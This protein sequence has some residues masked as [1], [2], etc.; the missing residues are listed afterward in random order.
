MNDYHTGY[1][2]IIGRPNVGKSTLLNFLLEQ[3]LSIVSRK[4]Q[5]TRYNLLGIKTTSN[6]QIIY[7]DTPGLQKK[8][9]LALNRYMN[10]EVINAL[11]HVDIIL[12]VVE[13][14][15]WNELDDNVVSVLGNIK[16]KILVL[17]NKTDK[18]INKKELLPFIEKINSKLDVLDIIPISAKKGEGVGKL[19]EFI[20][21]NLPKGPAIFSESS[22]TDR[23]ERFFAAEFLREK[24]M[25]R[26]GEEI[27]YR[28]TIT[29]DSFQDIDNIY[30]IHASIWV[31]KP[32]QK[33]IVIGK[34]GRILKAAGQEARLDLEKL[35][36]KK[37]NLKTWVK[38]KN[39]W[40]DSEQALKQFGYQ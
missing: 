17:I 34:Q 28:F 2:S 24:L 36:G 38:V 19:E 6:C 27:P 5:T 30:H 11:S 16:T 29:I 14:L 31:E 40:T 37:V 22:I 25:S 4:P 21:Q 13:A 9:G 10:R 32:G 3:K 26:L 33:A 18:L 12:F 23:S 15:H 20:Y 39:K 35:F 7:I 1:V 8:P